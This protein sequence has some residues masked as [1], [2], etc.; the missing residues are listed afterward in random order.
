M[1][2]PYTPEQTT[3]IIQLTLKVL[4]RDVNYSRSDIISKIMPHVENNADRALKGFEAMVKAKTIKSRISGKYY[5]N[6]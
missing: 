6:C 3:A 5:R 1:P 4:D 2:I